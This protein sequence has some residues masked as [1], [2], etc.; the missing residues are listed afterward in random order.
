MHLDFQRAVGGLVHVLGEFMDIHRVKG[1]VRI[2][3]RH[4]P[5]LGLDLHGHPGKRRYGA[6]EIACHLHL[7]NSLSLIIITS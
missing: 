2:G 4:V 6:G 1:G 7:E 5:C 3:R